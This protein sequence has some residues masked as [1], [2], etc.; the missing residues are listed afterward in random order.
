[1]LW[2]RKTEDLSDDDWR[3]GFDRLEHDVRESGKLGEQAWPPTYA[4]FVGMCEPPVGQQAHKY[5]DRSTGL[6]DLTAK[7]K[8][9]T[10]GHAE[11]QKILGIFDD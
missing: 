2:C 1:L 3:R 5:F 4:A 6:E 7:E 8:R 11:C 10:Q 9:Q